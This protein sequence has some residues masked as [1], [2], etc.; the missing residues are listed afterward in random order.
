MKTL[1]HLTTLIICIFAGSTA[2]AQ[3]LFIDQEPLMVQNQN[4]TYCWF[5]NGE[6]TPIKQPEGKL[7]S[8][9]EMISMQKGVTARRE[10]VIETTNI[11]S[12]TDP[13]F[14][15]SI[16][17]LVY[18]YE[19]VLTNSKII[20][21]KSKIYVRGKGNP[22]ALALFSICTLIMLIVATLPTHKSKTS[23]WL[24][25]ASIVSTMLASYFF[26]WW[27]YGVG[28]ACAITATWVGFS[29]DYDDRGFRTAVVAVTLGLLS[30]PLVD[31]WKDSQS[32]TTFLLTL[33]T[34][35]ALFFTAIGYFVGM[36]AEKEEK[37]E[38]LELAGGGFKRG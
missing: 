17:E 32:E 28:L 19:F 2:K 9:E 14:F 33:I 36:F 34:I 10:D 38:E 4:G 3:P 27:G 15:F 11:F 1:M 16:N 18:E 22:W 35:S 30:F 25:G 8:W 26:G 21:G 6:L 24:V 23:F 20:T 13:P 5:M 31:E 12:L 7:F 37:E 29:L